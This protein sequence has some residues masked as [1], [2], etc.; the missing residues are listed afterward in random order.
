MDLVAAQMQQPLPMVLALNLV[1]TDC[2]GD[3]LVQPFLA[4]AILLCDFGT[5]PT[6]KKTHNVLLK[7]K[8]Y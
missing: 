1:N 5:K 8:K 3:R 6:E 2:T 7:S 4:C